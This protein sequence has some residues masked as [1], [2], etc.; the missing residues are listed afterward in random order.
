MAGNIAICDDIMLHEL[1]D[2]ADW[3]QGIFQGQGQLVKIRSRR[4]SDY[5]ISYEAIPTVYMEFS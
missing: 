3:I 4:L 2:Y 5:T 1:S